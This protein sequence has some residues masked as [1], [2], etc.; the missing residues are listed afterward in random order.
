LVTAVGAGTCNIIYTVTGGCNGTPTALQPY[1]VT[2][3]A[4]AGSV[5]AGTT[6]QCTGQTTTYAVSG[7]VL[8]GG[9]GGW[10]SDDISVATVNAAT[11]LVTAVGAGTCNIIYTV[12][13]GCNGTPTSSQPYT[14]TPNAS[15]GTVTA[16]TTPQCTGQTTTYTVS[17]EVLGGGTGG[18]TS[19]DISVATV[20]AATGLV[21]AVGA[22]T[23]N[24]IYTVTGGCNG[25]PT[26]QQSQTVNDLPNATFSY[27]GTPYCSN[28]T[29]PLPTFN[30][31]GVAGTFSST[32]GLV[33][34]STATGEVDLSASTAGTYTVA[35]TIAAGSGCPQ[36]QESG[37]ITITTAPTATISYSGSPY[38]SNAVSASVTLI[39]TTGGVYSSVPAGLS[40][41]ASTGEVNIGSS[42][43]GN[44]TVTYNI[45]ALGGCGVVK[46]VT[47][48]IITQIPT[49]V[50]SYSGSPYC[51]NAG[52]IPVTLTGIFGGDYSSLPVGLSLNTV[53]GA[54]DAG[55]STPGTYTVSYTIAAVGGC[56]AVTATSPFIITPPVGTPVF[57]IGATSTRT[58]GAGTITYNATATNSTDI[59]YTLSPAGTS[60]IN[61]ASG[62]VTWDPSY[63]GTA[64]ITASASGCGGPATAIHTVTVNS[65]AIS[66]NLKVFLEGYYTGSSTMRTAIAYI[67]GHFISKWGMTITDTI[68]VVLHDASDYNIVVYTA[69]GVPLHT[70]GQANASIPGIYYNGSYFISI[71]QRNHLE[72]VSAAAVL[73]NA[74]SV[75]YNF[76]DQSSKTYENN[77][78]DISGNGLVWGLYS[79]DITQAGMEYHTTPNPT[80]DGM[81]DQDDLYYVFDSYLNGDYGYYY[82]DINGDGMVDITDLYLTFDNYLLG[83]YVATP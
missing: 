33:F 83:V 67:G 23:C 2:S 63:S 52:I 24:I 57:I 27:T 68:T 55:L 54:V 61:P 35:N 45:A 73:L 8:G 26:A 76:S 51:T 20:N 78:K 40:I 49:A 17:G 13:G 28:A 36:V 65:S 37:S 64:F 5:T 70:N 47:S 30:G 29:D 10:T 53:N 66:L 7:E 16:G 79:G 48:V 74:T 12:T 75:N 34:I 11:G 32:P 43:P 9:A 77:V 46:A 81:I 39:G 58:Q 41:N 15:A 18:W 80:Q 60:S 22:G 4:S 14:V 3:N 19:D 38:C 59:T 6:P 42:T 82:Q 31:G 56:S 1:T 21:T 25:T 71:K 44:Y 50:I 72:A 69:Y 62:E